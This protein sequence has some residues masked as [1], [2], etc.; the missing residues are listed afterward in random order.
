MVRSSRRVRHALCISLAAIVVP[1]IACVR[2]SLDT[3]PRP[4]A[5]TELR[6]LGCYSIRLMTTQTEDLNP[7]VPRVI[8]PLVMRLDSVPLTHGRTRRLN[9]LHLI[10]DTISNRF[11]VMHWE[12]RDTVADRGVDSVTLAFWRG[13][14]G[15]MMRLAVYVDSLSGWAH[16]A[17]DFTPSVVYARVVACRIP[18]DS[19]W[20][21]GPSTKLPLSQGLLQTG[22]STPLFSLAWRARR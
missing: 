18:C 7:S 14:T 2:R 17:S 21:P 9:S 22:P 20:N 15:T 4:L 16:R 1:V 13:S 10:G 3:L 11:T 5:D 6:A 19:T 12:D 8:S